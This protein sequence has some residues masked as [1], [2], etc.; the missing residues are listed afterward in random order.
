LCGYAGQRVGPIRYLDDA[1]N[2]RFD[3]IPRCAEVGACRARRAAR[4]KPWP[5]LDAPPRQPIRPG[6]P[7]V[8]RC[9]W[10]GTEGTEAALSASP[11]A[12]R[13]FHEPDDST[14]PR[15]SVLDRIR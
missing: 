9:R 2:V 4:G 12:D 11:C 13:P 14:R 1:G 15:G 7:P 6:G 8:M 10:C 3:S 5:L